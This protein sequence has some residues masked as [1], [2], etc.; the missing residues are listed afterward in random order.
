LDF[1]LPVSLQHGVRVDGDLGDDF[2]YGW[3]PV[4]GLEHPHAQGL[5]DLL[6]DLEVGGHPRREAQLEAERLP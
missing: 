5:F 4:A 1:E 6:D 3:Q 2:F